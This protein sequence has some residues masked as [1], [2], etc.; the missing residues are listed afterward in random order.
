MSFQADLKIYFRKLSQYSFASLRP[1]EDLTLAL[2][3]EQS[4]FVRFTQAKV[5]QTTALEQIDLE[6]I[7]QMGARKFSYV[8]NLCRN[9]DADCRMMDT[10]L[11]RARAEI[12]VAPED[13]YLKPVQNHGSSEEDHDGTPL[14]S[15]QIAPTICKIA[16]GHDL[17]GLYCGGPLIRASAN[18]KGQWHWF[19][20]NSF[21][22]DYSLYAKNIDGENKASRGIYSEKN[23]DPENFQKKLMHSAGEIKMLQKRSKKVLPGEYN[24]FLTPTATGELLQ[25]LSWNAVSLSAYKEGNS[26][27]KKFYDGEESLSP[28]VSLRENFGLGISPRFNSQGELAPE[29]LTIIDQG[30]PKNWLVTSRASLEYGIASNGADAGIFGMEGLRSP[31]LMAGTLAM[32]NAISQLGT[33]LYLGY[34]H[35]LNWSSLP[36]ARITGMTRYGCFWVENGEIVAPIHDLRFDESLYQC[37]GKNLRAITREQE[38]EPS[39]DTYDQRSL[40]GKKV[41]GLLIDNFTFTL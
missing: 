20:T 14:A 37:L 7:L 12:E 31:E 33:G 1:S 9:W 5:R 22:V 15:D 4:Q 3:A 16:N 32:E 8:F 21:F 38:I 10:A 30:K 40:G 36:L 19:S 35:Y 11:A 17:A 23:F 18:S 2:R 29:T 27:F 34:L 25:M 6:F 28:L 24:V 13:P 41:P 26:A 39:I